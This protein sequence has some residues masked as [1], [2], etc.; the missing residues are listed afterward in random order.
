MLAGKW[1]EIRELNQITLLIDGKRI[2]IQC[3]LSQLERFQSL[4]EAEKQVQEE[5]TSTVQKIAMD[6]YE[7]AEIVLNPKPNEIKF[8]REEIQDKIDVDQVNILVKTWIER[9][10]YAPRIEA[11]PILAPLEKGKAGN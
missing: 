11:D 9:K 8:S 1:L 4:T 7:L 5:K 3:T 6:S 2:P 10:V